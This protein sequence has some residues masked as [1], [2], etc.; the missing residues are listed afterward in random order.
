MAASLDMVSV[1]FS[2]ALGDAMGKNVFG[3]IRGGV[4]DGIVGHGVGEVDDGVGR[5]D[6]RKY[7]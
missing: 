7:F 4:G 3:G 1:R 5:C 2:T 6:G